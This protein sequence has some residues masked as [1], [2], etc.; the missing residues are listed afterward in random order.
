M[1]KNTKCFV[2]LHNHKGLKSVLKAVHFC[3]KTLV[4]P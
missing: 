2:N 4:W 3:W 1:T